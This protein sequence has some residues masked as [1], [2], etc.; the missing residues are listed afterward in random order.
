MK[1][2][3]A[4]ALLVALTLFC[5]P[6]AEAFSVNITN[7]SLVEVSVFIPVYDSERLNSQ[8][9]LIQARLAPNETLTRRSMPYKYHTVISVV[10]RCYPKTCNRINICTSGKIA[11]SP[12]DCAFYQFDMQGTIIYNCT[13]CTCSL[14]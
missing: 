7:G 6:P 12:A 8:S 5:V 10:P 9:S 4:D 13:S 11:S 14:Q 3:Y 1:V 2:D